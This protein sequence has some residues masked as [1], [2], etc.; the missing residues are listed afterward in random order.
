MHLEWPECDGYIRV[1]SGVRPG[2]VVSSWYDPM[3]AKVIAWGKDRKEAIEKLTEA[4]GQTYLTGLKNNRDY[5]LALINHANFRKEEL[6]TSFITRHFD[7]G[8]AELTDIQ[9]K[10]LLAVAGLYRYHKEAVAVAQFPSTGITP[11]S[12]Y[13]YLDGCEHCIQVKTDGNLYLLTFA[14][15]RHVM[16]VSWK[17]ERYGLSGL[18][19]GE[20]GGQPVRVFPLPSQ[21]L[22]VFL[23]DCS[24]VIGSPGAQIGTNK[25]TG[26][27][28]TAPMNGTVTAVN[29]QAGESVKMGELLLVMEAMKM[30]YSIKAPYDG[31]IGLVDLQPGDQV[32]SGSALMAYQDT[33]G[34]TA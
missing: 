24:A 31:V 22:A 7:Q 34:A 32:E 30:E 23:P 15:S 14:D 12:A 17:D 18:L 13:F 5:L 16:S 19:H 26:Q 21:Q 9:T 29:V 8:A 3:L 20:Q 2:D 11:S 1:D 4:L 6:S 27:V 25:D 33:T 10:H 28:L